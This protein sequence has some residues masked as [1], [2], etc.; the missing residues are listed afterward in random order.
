M[1]NLTGLHISYKAV[2]VNAE[3]HLGIVPNKLRTAS[4]KEISY[5][6]KKETAAAIQ[7]PEAAGELINLTELFSRRSPFSRAQVWIVGTTPLIVHAWS[8]KAKKEMLAKQV[9][10]TKPGRDL[11]DPQQDFVDSLYEIGVDKKTGRNMYGFPAMGL[12]NAIL[13][14]S[15]KDKGV[16]RTSV[17]QSLWIDAPI[18]QTR[19]A[20]EGAVCDMPIIP[21]H[22]SAPEM[23]ED[24]VKIGAGLQ[25]T[26]NL[27]YRGQFKTWAMRLDLR[28]NQTTLTPEALAFLIEESG[29]SIGIGEWRNERRGVFGSYRIASAEEEDA[30]K[31]YAF[32]KGSLPVTDQLAEVA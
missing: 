24:M 31:S 14:V 3:M 32:G 29:I 26:A 9:K 1:K 18:V 20:L 4:N 21:I 17:M 23:R 13:S 12:K 10:A 15:H 25:K 8:E 19:P 11:R 30:W 22:G 2:L 28:F 16:A 27:A 6:A 5:M 7:P